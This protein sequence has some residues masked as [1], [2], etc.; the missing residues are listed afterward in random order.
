M[1]SPARGLFTYDS[2]LR[3]SW[4][5][6]QC[7]PRKVTITHTCDLFVC[8]VSCG[9][10]R[11][12]V[13]LSF[14][15]A[16]SLSVCVRVCLCWFFGTWCLLVCVCVCLCLSL[17]FVVSG[18]NVSAGWCGVWSRSLSWSHHLC[19]SLLFSL[20]FR[21][22]SLARSLTQTAPTPTDPQIHAFRCCCC[23]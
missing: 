3:T 2:E 20:A 6:P 12:S 16:L 8:V 14:S 23:C 5:N 21:S 22:L 1:V 17:E 13:S 10:V 15:R 9:C 7:P 4:Y 11:L 18:G 19:L